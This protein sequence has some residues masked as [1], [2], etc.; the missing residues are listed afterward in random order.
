[1]WRERRPRKGRSWRGPGVL[2]LG[3]R[4]SR[5][6]RRRSSSIRIVIARMRS[7]TMCISKRERSVL[8]VYILEYGKI[9]DELHI[10]S[11][12]KTRQ[13][14]CNDHNHNHI[15]NHERHLLKLEAPT[16]L[17]IHGQWW[18][19]RLT[20]RLQI[21]QWC[22]KGGLKV[23]HCPHME[24]LVESLLWLSIG[25]AHLGTDPGSVKEVLAWDE[26]ASTTRTVYIIPSMGGIPSV[27]VRAVT[28]TAEYIIRSHTR[29]AIMD[30]AWSPEF[31][32]IPAWWGGGECGEMV[33]WVRWVSVV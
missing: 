24:W 31:I 6:L 5:H 4:C 14:Y 2:L 32:Q 18:S 8:Y 28:V 21:L 26:R 17:F 27:M 11:Q 22:E 30:P 7:W 20:H 23:W 33:W 9:S 10:L 12:E 16:Q 25:T 13:F 1:M 19:I 29:V 15:H 3:G